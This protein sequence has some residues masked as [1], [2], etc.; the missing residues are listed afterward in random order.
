M[1]YETKIHFFCEIL[2]SKNGTIRPKGLQNTNFFT[3]NSARE[4]KNQF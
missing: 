2:K 4:L 1:F 3:Q